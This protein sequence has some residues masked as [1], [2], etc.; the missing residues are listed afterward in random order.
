MPYAHPTV[1]HF[2]PMFLTLGAATDP[3]VTPETMIDGW[4][5]VQ[6]VAALAPGGL[7]RRV[8]SCMPPRVFKDTKGEEFGFVRVLGISCEIW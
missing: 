5:D 1:E 7:R 8:A 3:T 4:M 6:I 2:I